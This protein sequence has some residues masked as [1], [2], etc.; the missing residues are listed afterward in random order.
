MANDLPLLWIAPRASLDFGLPQPF[1]PVAEGA[2]TNGYLCLDH[3][4]EHIEGKRPRP[5]TRI[6]RA[7][8]EDIRTSNASLRVP[9][10]HKLREAILNVSRIEKLWVATPFGLAMATWITAI[11]NTKPT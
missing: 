2:I 8:S 9:R 5:G 10:G 1:G 6:N 11:P 3:S 4:Y 7:H